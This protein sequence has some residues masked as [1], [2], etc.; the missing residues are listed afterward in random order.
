MVAMN[1]VAFSFVSHRASTLKRHFPRTRLTNLPGQWL[2]CRAN[3]SNVCRVLR[4]VLSLSWRAPGCSAI[5]QLVGSGE[6]TC[7]FW[8]TKPP[9]MTTSSPSR[10]RLSLS[11]SLSLSL[12]QR[13]RHS[14][15][16]S[17]SLSP[18]RSVSVSVSISVSVSLSLSLSLSSALSPSLSG[19][20][21]PQPESSLPALWRHRP[22]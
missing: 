16:L 3:G 1:M 22:V 9:S 12:S 13:Q 7:G 21:W 15:S 19:P 6:T 11:V 2:Q 5:C 4:R 14:L 18:C 8:T 10:A 17:L 20:G